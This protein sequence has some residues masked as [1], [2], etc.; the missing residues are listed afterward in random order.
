MK[1]LMRVTALNAW[2]GG[3]GFVISFS[4]HGDPI[5]RALTAVLSI[6][7]TV[8][9][10]RSVWMVHNIDKIVARDK[11]QEAKERRDEGHH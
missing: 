8:S 2:M 10:I 3:A 11:A 9:A 7:A 1:Q 4:N 6:L 5:M